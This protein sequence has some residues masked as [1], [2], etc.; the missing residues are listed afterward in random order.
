MVG[1]DVTINLRTIRALPL[2]L[3]PQPSLPAHLVVRGR[4]LHALDEFQVFNRRM[5]ERGEEAFANPR[6]AAAGSFAAV[7]QPHHRVATLDPDL[8][9]HHGDIRH[10]SIHPLEELDALAAWGLP[11]LANS[12]NTWQSI[13]EVL[14]LSLRPSML[15]R[16]SLTV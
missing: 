7:G 12:G 6:N 9:R 15:L 10:S 2:Q 4:S 14:S 5:T 1:E 11:V 8:L 13:E 16:D 3:D